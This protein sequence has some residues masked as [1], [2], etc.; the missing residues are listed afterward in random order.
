MPTAYVLATIKWNILTHK[1]KL[2]LIKLFYK[3]YYGVLP[4]ALAEQLIVLSNRFVSRTKHE[5]IVPRFASNYVKNSIAYRGTVLWNA[6]SRP[7][8]SI[9]D[10]TDM[11]SFLKKVIK[12]CTFNDFNFKVLAPQTTNNR[13]ENFFIFL[14]LKFVFY[15]CRI[16][17]PRINN[18]LAFYFICIFA[19]DPTSL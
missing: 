10:C 4:H 1:Y 7:N 14:I 19:H 11:K 5:L 16:L 3:G 13:S 6:I 17:F 15:D 18:F 8:S 12:C 2:S 9:F